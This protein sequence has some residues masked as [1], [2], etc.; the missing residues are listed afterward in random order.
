MNT[1]VKC[2]LI[3]VF[4]LLFD[5]CS[6]QYNE[7][8]VLVPLSV[9]LVIGVMLFVTLR[10]TITSHCILN[11]C[12]IFVPDPHCSSL[13]SHGDGKRPGGCADGG[14]RP[15]VCRNLGTLYAGRLHRLSS[16]WC[17]SV[18]LLVNKESV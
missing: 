3:T 8:N 17:I 1:S 2:Y 16:S 7:K 12:A 11:A 6:G 10:D 15:E 9:K 18:P 13:E 14:E 5:A 4:A